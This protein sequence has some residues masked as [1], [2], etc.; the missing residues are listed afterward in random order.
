MQLAALAFPTDPALLALVP[1]AAT[2][3]Q[4][5]PGAVRRR[6]IAKIEARDARGGLLDQRGVTLDVL[7]QA[8]GPVR[9]QRE[10]Q[11]AFGT[12]KMVDFQTFDLLVDRLPSCQHR[13]NR[14][15]RP[16]LGGNA[17][18][19]FET[20]QQRRRVAQIDS[21][22][23]ESDG[24]VNG[25]N[26]AE[27][28]EPDQNGKTQPLDGQGVKRH[29]EQQRGDQSNSCDITADPQ[30]SMQARQPGSRRRAKLERRLK[31]GATASE[32]II[33]EVGAARRLGLRRRR[34]LA[35]RRRDRCVRDFQFGSLG[36]AR[37]FF[38]GA[39]VKRARRKIH[40]LEMAVGGKCRVDKAY[41]LENL[42]PIRVPDQ[43]QAGDDVS[44]RDIGRA[45]AAVNFA[46][47]GFGCRVL[48]RQPLIEPGQRRGDF[49]VLV[50]QAVRELNRER[51]RNRSALLHGEHHRDRF[52]G[53]AARAQQ[54][55]GQLVGDLSGGEAL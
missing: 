13:R 42:L 51:L 39:A 55:V 9:Q 28:D 34:L 7:G 26:G 11:I 53:P 44:Y 6:A 4:H 35:R 19:Q 46:N 49:R 12:G 1:D 41:S 37:Q 17:V 24:G 40:V 3:Q 16:E 50:T 14:D 5:E 25:R 21:A 48:K 30:R 8:V 18:P 43:S 20:R 31:G 29:S 2:M 36:A 52:G 38:D 15:D 47:G 10:M 27:P 22:I 32:Q 33:A 54:A 23:C 45:L